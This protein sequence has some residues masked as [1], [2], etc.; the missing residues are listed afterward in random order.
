M[1]ALF[2]NELCMIPIVYFVL[3]CVLIDQ[4]VDSKS[5]TAAN[6]VLPITKK[7]HRPCTVQHRKKS[8]KK[9]TGTK[10]KKKAKK[11]WLQKN[12]SAS[13][14]NALEY[15]GVKSKSRTKSKKQKD[16]FHRKQ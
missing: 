10:K 13:A 1:E 3:K 9:P 14:I 7:E 5:P 8:M 11:P 16:Y 12:H 15:R 6:N 4:N 2:I